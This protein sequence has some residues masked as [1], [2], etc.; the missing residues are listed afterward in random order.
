MAFKENQKKT[1]KGRIPIKSDWLCSMI[2]STS[3]GESTGDE[4]SE[5]GNEKPIECR[6][7]PWMARK[8]WMPQNVGYRKRIGTETFDGTKKLDSL[9]QSHWMSHTKK[10]EWITTRRVC[11]SEKREI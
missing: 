1:E 3:A 9:K 11:E 2:E 4:M 7:S 5:G 10:H 8:H 6:K